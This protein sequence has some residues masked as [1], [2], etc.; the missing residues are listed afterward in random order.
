[1][2]GSCF[3]PT[4]NATMYQLR[5]E[6]A[7]NNSAFVAANWSASDPDVWGG[8]DGVNSVQCDANGRVTRL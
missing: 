6:L 4:D 8:Y 7:V 1:M 3:D 2:G 5:A